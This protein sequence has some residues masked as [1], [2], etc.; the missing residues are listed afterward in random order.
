V[1]AKEWVSNHFNK[2]MPDER[3]PERR[4]G[5]HLDKCRQGR[6]EGMTAGDER[7]ERIPIEHTPEVSETSKSLIE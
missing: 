2:Q 4:T 6:G 1:S 7:G 3:T 5:D